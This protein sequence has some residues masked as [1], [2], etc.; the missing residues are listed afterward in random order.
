MS[1]G[2]RGRLRIGVLLALATALAPAAIAEP[3]E[4]ASPA[5][6]VGFDQKLG[7]DV[8]RDLEFRDE[9]GRVVH[10]GDY[11][12]KRPLVLQLAYYEC[13]ML[14]GMAIDGLATSLK[15]V[16]L[17]PGRD[18]DLL[19]VSFKPDE[20]PEQARKRKASA[21]EVLGG[22]EAAQAWHFLTGQAPAIDALT[23]TVGFRYAWDEEQQQYAHATGIV[24]LTPEGRVAR[25]FFGVEY[26]P[27]DLRF[28]LMEASGGRIGTLA[29]QLLLLCYHYNP[30][31]GRYGAFAMTSI[32]AG[33]L[34]TLLGLGALVLLLR[35]QERKRSLPERE[36]RE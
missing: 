34:I 9:Q 2:T 25:Y 15:A 22:T 32:R 10:L 17:V 21:M 23:S 12:G 24:I 26:K 30:A 7:A 11:F 27:R 4:P 1:P 5:S 14:C 35:R 8:P 28:G 31:T 16:A 36:D 20:T 33:G 18:F 6:R 3:I 19:T 29:D 13:P